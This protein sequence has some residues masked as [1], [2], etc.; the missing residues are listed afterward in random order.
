MHERLDGALVR[1][2]LARSRTRAAELVHDGVVRVDGR[3]ARKPSQPV[4]GEQSLE[5]LAEDRYVS[6]GAHKLVGALDDVDALAPG[7]LVV[8]ERSCLD[9]GA[10]T[11]GFTQVLLERGAAHVRAVDVGHGQLDPSLLRDPRVTCVEGVNA[12]D[13]APSGATEA[14][15]GSPAGPIAP[16]ATRGSQAAEDG[17]EPAERVDAPTLVVADLSFISLT[18]VVAPVVRAAAPGADLLLMVKPQFEVG[19]ERL[20]RGGVVADPR[21][22]VGAVTDVARALEAEGAAVLAVLP[23]RLPG[24]HGNLEYFLWARVGGR[25]TSADAV[26]RSVATAVRGA[27]PVLVGGAP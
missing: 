14:G 11:G 17:A 19:R 5:V 8:L 3:P 21:L 23:S 10:S 22:R 9:V 24:E 4:S 2:G 15:H 27:R 16:A 18:L 26:E 1:R 20:G 12:R 6:R 25:S 13:L 7:A